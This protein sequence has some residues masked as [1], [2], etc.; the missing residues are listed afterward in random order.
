MPRYRIRFLIPAAFFLL[1]SHGCR[2]QPA[3]PAPASGLEVSF[4]TLNAD[5]VPTTVFRYGENIVFDYAARNRTGEDLAW[6]G[7][8]ASFP[9]S[10]T[11]L[12]KNT[13]VG[14]TLTGRDP[15]QISGVLP[16]GA[17][18][19]YRT[20]WQANPALPRLVPGQYEVWGRLS[21]SFDAYRETSARTASITVLPPAGR[22]HVFS[23]AKEAWAFG[24]FALEE[25]DLFWASI[26]RNS[27][28]QYELTASVLVE[29]DDPE[30]ACL[31]ELGLPGNGTNRCLRQEI[32]SPVLLDAA[33]R[34]ALDELILEFPSVPP[35]INGACDP[36]MRLRYHLGNDI[37]HVNPCTFGPQEYLDH[38]WDLAEFV[39]GLV[40]GS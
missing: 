34:N 35:R 14:G 21:F 1:A 24:T 16:D 12:S 29:S 36:A 20:S 33:Q 23:L 25:G 8:Y 31:P 15:S 2:D 10:F 9:A 32:L 6:H 3:A 7:Y 19:A 13:S 22:Q 37:R 11:C 27:S 28:D 5:G 38:A 30:A 39:E 17:V 4:R 40:R 26:F 18:I